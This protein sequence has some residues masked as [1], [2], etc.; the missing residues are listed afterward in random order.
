MTTTHNTSRIAEYAE[1]FG[2]I[3][4]AISTNMIEQGREAGMDDEHIAEAIKANWIAV[5]KAK[6]AA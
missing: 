3:F 4:A 5:L 6:A 2:E 1:A